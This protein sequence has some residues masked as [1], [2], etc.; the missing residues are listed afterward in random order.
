MS[1]LLLQFFIISLVPLAF[2]ALFAYLLVRQPSSRLK[3]TR[4]WLVTL[5]LIAAWS[6]RQLTPYL[7]VEVDQFVTYFWQ[8][9][10]NYPL[11]LAGT[12]ILLATAAYLSRPFGK[13]SRWLVLAGPLL[14]A[15]AFLVDP[16]LWPGRIPSFEISQVVVRQFDLW[17]WVWVAAWLIPM[18]AGWLMTEQIMRATPAS[19]Y[20]NQVVIWLVILSLALLGGTLGLVRDLLLVQQTGALGLLVG[21]FL[22]TLAIVRNQMPNLPKTAR[23]L[24]YHLLRGGIAFLL[25][26]AVLYGL[27]NLLLNAQDTAATI[28]IAAALLALTM[29]VVLAVANRFARSLIFKEEEDQTHLINLEPIQNGLLSPA[30]VARYLLQEIVER[31]DATGGWLAIVEEGRA[32]G[33]VIRPLAGDAP[34]APVSLPGDSPFVGHF[35]NQQTPLTQPDIAYLPE[36]SNLSSYEQEMHQ[37]WLVTAYIPLHAHQRLIGLAGVKQKKSG[38]LYSAA[39]VDRMTLLGR[40]IGPVLARSQAITALKQAVETAQTQNSALN[41]EW[42]R[43]RE[44]VDFYQQFIRLLS[45]EQI[46]QPFTDLTIQ[47]QQLESDLSSRLNGN[48]ESFDQ[49]H[50]RIEESQSLVDNLIAVASHLEKQSRFDLRPV[51][52]D[53]VIRSAMVMLEDMAAARRVVQD[54][55]VRGQILPVWGDRERLEE[56]IHQLLHNAIKFNRIGGQIEV[57]CQMQRDE[58]RIDIRDQGVGIPEDRL[59]DLWRGLEKTPS[60][61]RLGGRRRTRIGLPLVNFIVKAHGGR[62]EVESSYGRGSTF[63]I[64]LPARLAE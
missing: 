45:P 61:E 59:D 10:A 18:I 5:I 28:I 47:L 38:D 53:E 15:I 49:I 46:R 2:L 20:R 54:L 12:S 40:E 36:F 25:S 32:G 37:N 64:Y 21:M 13:R 22:G 50:E 44:L 57:Q 19:I 48:R 9:Y 63:H 6:S 34:S 24:T 62:V 51:Y 16:A 30:D 17:A 7:G 55:Q 4:W 31:L 26:T 3:L 27:T 23:R 35:L 42:Q 52:M 11:V 56:A 33:M 39:D 41:Q 8:V 58:V 29:L 14:A 43:L 60:I 1:W